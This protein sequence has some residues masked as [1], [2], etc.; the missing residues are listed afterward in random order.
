VSARPFQLLVVVESGRPWRLPAALEGRFTVREISPDGVELYLQ[1][2]SA[3]AV[4]V[5]TDRHTEE[6]PARIK[7]WKSLRPK[8][9]FLV[10]LDHAP[11]TRALV[12][13]MH[14]GCQDVVDRPG[15][16]DLAALLDSLADRI[17]FVRM[18][19]ME[20]LQAKQSAQ[21]TGLVG[22]SPEMIRVYDQM[23]RAAALNCPV[24]IVGETGTG[25][26][27][28]AHAIH[29]LSLRSG[30]PFVTVDCG[31]L[32]PTLIESELYG[33][34]RGAFT[35][36]TVDRSGLVQAAQEGTLFLDEIGELPLSMQPKLLRLL[37]EGEV[38]RLG[39]QR[40]TPVDVRVVSATSRDLESLIAAE[41][42]RLDLYFRLN[43]LSIAL[44]PLRRRLADVPILARHF[45][46]RHF[47][48][49]EP[50]TITDAAIDELLQYPWPG[51]VRELK[52]C[53]EAAIAAANSSTIHPHHL[54][55]RFRSGASPAV[56]LADTVNLK[57]L[58]RR[59]IVR[60]MEMAGEDKIRAAR[61][62]GIG[63][64]TLYRKLKGMVRRKQAAHAAGSGGPTYLM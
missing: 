55:G 23:L 42:F 43:V 17:Q 40:P 35:G 20:R 3:D 2:Q 64:T 28:V 1:Q 63:K 45:A 53:L 50:V 14:A 29:A 12:G 13:L 4:L 10:V 54:P 22:E 15:S 9:Q 38:R 44:P 11:P 52:N 21:Y 59:A 37:E 5:W 49:G 30:K 62:L 24:L 32:A 48:Q 34:T 51:N 18:H 25:K 19:Q 27:L 60:A 33:V 7:R 36:A 47:V 6:L 31:C 57:E 26:G 8:T 56:P 46:S 61:L 41:E 39:S 58:E 16:T